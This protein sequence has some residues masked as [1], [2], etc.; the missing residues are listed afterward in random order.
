M[1]SVCVIVPHAKAR[2]VFLVSRQLRPHPQGTR[3]KRVAIT[4]FMDKSGLRGRSGSFTV[5]CSGSNAFLLVFLAGELL[6]ETTLAC[7][8]SIHQLGGGGGAP[9]RHCPLCSANSVKSNIGSASAHT[10]PST[11]PGLREF[12]FRVTVTARLGLMGCT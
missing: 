4:C 3:R 12:G 8:F 11:N 7:R 9:H 1:Y 10:S 2:N 5:S 6:L